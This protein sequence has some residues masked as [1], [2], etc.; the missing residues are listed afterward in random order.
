MQS[1]DNIVRFRD[2]ARLSTVSPRAKRKSKNKF[3][4]K[5]KVQ[6]ANQS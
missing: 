1:N 3:L 2:T 4:K 6:N 5:G